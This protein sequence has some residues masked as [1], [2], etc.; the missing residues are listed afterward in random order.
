M[1]PRKA[2]L[3]PK[4]T[5]ACTSAV[6]SS[7]GSFLNRK[8]TGSIVQNPRVFSSLFR[9]KTAQKGEYVYKPNKSHDKKSFFTEPVHFVIQI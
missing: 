8:G 1:V 6:F 4:I 2:F 5:V 7:L 9:P 3:S